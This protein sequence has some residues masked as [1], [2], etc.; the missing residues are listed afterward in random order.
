MAQAVIRSF[1][2][3]H[4]F[5]SNFYAG[6]GGDVTINRIHYATTEH[7][8]QAGKFTSRKLRKQV[9]G[10]ATPGD[11]KRY[12]RALAVKLGGNRAGWKD[13]DVSIYW[14][15]HVLRAKFSHPQMR[16]ALLETGDALLI[17]GNIW[18][19]DFWGQ[20]LVKDEWIGENW[21]GI[22]LMHIRKEL[23]TGKRFKFVPAKYRRG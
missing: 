5:L 1:R 23:R 15:L 17:E 2:S 16:E 11:A 7:A 14:M 18:G 12:A 6:I 13:A 20:I 10:C 4:F 22:I 19:D 3:K 9:A 21:L 8:F